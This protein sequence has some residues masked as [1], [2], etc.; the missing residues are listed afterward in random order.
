MIQMNRSDHHDQLIAGLQ[1][2]FSEKISVHRVTA[3]R[4]V[5]SWNQCVKSLV[6]KEQKFLIDRGREARSE[7]ELLF[8]Q[9][10]PNQLGQPFKRFEFLFGNSSLE[11]PS[12]RGFRN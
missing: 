11:H 5:S 4:P 1:T 2:V 9:T 6:L 10:L 7:G 3:S 8:L 12:A